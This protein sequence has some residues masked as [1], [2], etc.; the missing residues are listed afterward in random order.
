D[1]RAPLGELLAAGVER[2]ARA[3]ILRVVALRVAVDLHQ[4]LREGRQRR[5]REHGGSE[6]PLLHFPSFST[7]ASPDPPCA[8]RR[9]RLP[10]DWS[11][12]RSPASPGTLPPAC[13]FPRGGR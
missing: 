2:V 10:R 6:A 11:R 13:F 8:P 1:E 4:V 9:P 3:G 7:R 5:A 12:P